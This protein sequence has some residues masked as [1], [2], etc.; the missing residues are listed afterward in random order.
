V[1]LT[2]ARV[3]TPVIAAYLITGCAFFT[4]TRQDV[5]ISTNLA[6]AQIYVDGQLYGTSAGDGVPMTVNLKKSEPHVVMVSKEGYETTTGRFDKTLSSAGMADVIGAWIWL[7]PIITVIT[8]H[9]Y[10]LEPD[11]MFVPL[12]PAVAKAPSSQPAN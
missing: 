7:L 9:A 2:I 11:T 4:G 8:G 5:K 6:G 3:L 10:K 1:H 12:E